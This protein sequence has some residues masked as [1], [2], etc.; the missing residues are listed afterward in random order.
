MS[1]D[2]EGSL[3]LPHRLAGALL[4][5]HLPAAAFAGTVWDMTTEYPQGAMPGLG[6]TTFTQHVAR[7]TAGKLVIQPSFDAA[8]GVRSADM[9]AALAEGRVAAGDAFAGALESEDAIFALPSLPFLVTSIA[10][11]RRLADL[12]RPYLAAA[13]Q[14]RGARLLYLTPWPPTGIWSKAPLKTPSDLSGLSIR[15]YDRISREVFAGAGARAL[16]I[17]FADTLPRL[18]DG[19]INAV[20]SSGDGEAGRK[21]WGYLPYFAEITYSL[22]LSVASV[23]QAAYDALAPDLRDAVDTAGRQTETELWLAL[24]SRL[25]QNHQRMREAGVTI[26]ANPAPA[27]VAALQSRAAAMQQ[28]WCARSGLTCQK[29]LGV[30]K[31]GKP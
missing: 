5:L 20:L 18:A 29:V 22:P 13:L 17:S 30:F 1:V 8:K 19:S 12:A 23:G 11:A 3:R 24:S 9:L 26:D 4:L 16:S 27:I 14:N 21:L 2:R 10:D 31:T 25:Q 28:D 7:L 15:T 6:M